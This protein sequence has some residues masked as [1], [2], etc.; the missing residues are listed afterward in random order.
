MAIEISAEIVAEKGMNEDVS[1]VNVLRHVN[2]LQPHERMAGH[3]MST[4]MS[5]V[6]GD[7]AELFNVLL[8]LPPDAYRNT[9]WLEHL[10]GA[11]I[12]TQKDLTAKERAELEV[13]QK[14]LQICGNT[15]RLTQD[16][17][18]NVRQ[19]SREMANRTVGT[20]QED[21]QYAANSPPRIILQ[22]GVRIALKKL[23]LVSSDDMASK[24]ELPDDLEIQNATEQVLL[25]QTQMPL[26]RVA[27][28]DLL[29]ASD[30]YPAALRKKLSS[31]KSVWY[32]SQKKPGDLSE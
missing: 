15:L 12:H 26:F 7:K 31:L 11:G 30:I 3:H 22:Q 2:I 19:L 27:L 1:L 16:N 21:K 23:K 5:I 28:A 18:Q 20:S 6:E 9:S 14:I 29:G 32:F 13:Y 4:T 10:R 17:F 25:L 24:L 8:S